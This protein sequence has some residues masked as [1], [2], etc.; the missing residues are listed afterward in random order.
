[1]SLVMNTLP[2]KAPK[3]RPQVRHNQKLGFRSYQPQIRS[4]SSS[5]F[6]WPSHKGTIHDAKTPPQN[7]YTDPAFAKLELDNVLR[8]N[9]QYVGHLESLQENGSY[10]T[11][12]IFD[13]PY[14]VIK[15][16]DGQI[17]AFYN[18]CRHHAATLL[19]EESGSCK[20]P[21]ITCPY[22][23]WVYTTEGRLKKATKI[24]GI[25]DFAARDYGLVPIPLATIG[26][27]LFLNFGRE[28]GIKKEDFLRHTKE[29]VEQLEEMKWDKLKFL[30]R[31]LY[32]LKCNWKVFVENYLDGGYH[33]PVLH[34]DLTAQLSLSSYST[35]CYERAS[36]QGVKGGDKDE[37]KEKNK[38]GID[39]QERI[40]SRAVYAFLYPNLMINRY[41]RFLDIN[42]VVPTGTEESLVFFDYFFDD[43]AD[44]VLSQKEGDTRKAEKVGGVPLDEFLQKSLTASNKVQL[45]DQ[46]VCEIVQK[47]LKSDAY[48]EKAG[49]YSPQIETALFHFHQNFYT[50]LGIKEN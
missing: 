21:E 44:G 40:G 31:R 30:T 4:F 16:E 8:K 39:F 38:G 35:V 11:G 49:R 15:G 34:K 2:F 19:N 29:A 33:V 27:L 17:R 32:P 25:K 26:K 43:T 42:Y 41:G 36:V 45:E 18:V 23:G 24:A 1:M 46:F 13:Q 5:P 47:G 9:W 12:K 20:S 10:F 6:A 37:G 7:W 50:E 14:V 22:H 48:L 28:N 3:T